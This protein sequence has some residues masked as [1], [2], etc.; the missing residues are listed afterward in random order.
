MKVK[1]LKRLMSETARTSE[2]CW[3]IFIDVDIYRKASLHM[4]YSVILTSISRPTLL[5]VNFSERMRDSVKM[6]TTTFIEDGMLHR[7]AL[8]QIMYSVTLT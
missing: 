6:L 1:N 2:N 7:T 8:Q 5:N 3:L 4:V